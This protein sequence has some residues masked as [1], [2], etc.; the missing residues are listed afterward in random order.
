MQPEV[1][2]KALEPLFVDFGVFLD[3]GF[4]FFERDLLVLFV[5]VVRFEHI[6]RVFS[7]D[8]GRVDTLVYFT[9][10]LLL[11]DVSVFIY[12]LLF[13]GVLCLDVVVLGRLLAGGQFLLQGEV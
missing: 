7:E 2:M 1:V 5:Q 13:R 11:D 10:E 8:F 12:L 9:F 4:K 6:L 3:D